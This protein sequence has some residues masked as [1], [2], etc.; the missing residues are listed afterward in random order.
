MAKYYRKKERQIDYTS[1]DFQPC[2]TCKNACGGCVWS[3]EGKPIDGWEAIPTHI[4]DN[5][6]FADSYA[7]IK[8]P[9]YEFG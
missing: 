5:G 2:W 1:G 4:S 6:E 3:H 9:L 8:C 7:I